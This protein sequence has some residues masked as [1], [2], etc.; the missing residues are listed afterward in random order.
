M[1]WIQLNS[2][3]SPHYFVPLFTLNWYYNNYNNNW[4]F[5]TTVLF[6]HNFTPGWL[7][8]YWPLPALSGPFIY[9]SLQSA[10]RSQCRRFMILS[11]RELYLE[12]FCISIFIFDWPTWLLLLVYLEGIRCICWCVFAYCVRLCF[13]LLYSCWRSWCF[14]CNKL[15]GFA[16]AVVGISVYI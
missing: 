7:N 5:D 4:L 6:I 13:Y 1:L 3:Y 9:T 12:S 2:L 8:F 15:G 10:K 14:T 11:S 16:C